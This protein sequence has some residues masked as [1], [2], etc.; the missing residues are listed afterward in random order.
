M[1]FYYAA[2]SRLSLEDVC[3]QLRDRFSLEE[4]TFEE[5]D[6][7]RYGWAVN[8]QLH[9]NVTE[10]NDYCTIETWSSGCP[11]GV[12]YQVILTADAEPGDSDKEISRCLDAP[13]IKYAEVCS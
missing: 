13:A 3:S 10:A 4:F 8:R 11:K 6:N 5:H 1:R 2:R 12:N 7:W 9:V